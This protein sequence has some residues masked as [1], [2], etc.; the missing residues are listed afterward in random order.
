MLLIHDLSSE[1]FK[2]LSIDL[3]NNTK[4]ISKEMKDIHPCCGCFN[5]WLKTPGKCTINDDYTLMPKYI[6][7]NDIYIVISE[8]KYGCYSSYVKNVI[9]R[10]I[11]FLLPFMRSYKGETHHTI[12]YKNRIPKLIFIGYG[13]NIEEDEKETFK[14][15]SKAN[16]I[17]FGSE[18]KY[19]CY[20]ADNMIDIPEILK[21]IIK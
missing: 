15:I 2:N 7:E 5:C 1:K 10:S 9:E 19:E 12:R 11:G 16:A 8:I 6:V 21:S 13:E 3:P 4:V 17:N 14:E 20:I 18:N